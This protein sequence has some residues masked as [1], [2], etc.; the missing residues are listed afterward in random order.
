DE[1]THL[2]GPLNVPMPLTRRYLAEHLAD[3][4][5]ADQGLLI[6]VNGTAVSGAGIR[7]CDL[8]DVGTGW[9]HEPKPG[10]G[11]VAID[12]VLGRV[13]F[14]ETAGATPTVTF[15]YGQSVPVGGGAYDRDALTTVDGSV[16]RVASGG[17]LPAALGQ[18]ATGGTVELTGSGR[19]AAPAT[20]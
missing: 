11:Q 8:S 9:A 12:P 17:D 2:A 6:E 14:P 16:T 3:H 7:A 15:H 4:Y 13:C 18:A 20:I 19:Y 5:G 10:S 1:V